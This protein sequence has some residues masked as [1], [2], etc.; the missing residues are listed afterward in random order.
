MRF[1]LPRG[2][3]KSNTCKMKYESDPPDRNTGCLRGEILKARRGFGGVARADMDAQLPGTVTIS[4]MRRGDGTLR[5][6]SSDQR[7]LIARW[8]RRFPRGADAMRR[9]GSL[10]GVH[11]PWHACRRVLPG[12]SLG[13]RDIDVRLER[14]HTSPP[15]PG[16]FSLMPVLQ[17]LTVPLCAPIGSPRPP[18]R[19]ALEES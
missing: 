3:G 9:V 1:C 11:R 17:P 12:R 13:L 5:T 14:P 6:G 16:V 2:W 8:R 4:E 19:E 7:T 15:P 18:G 10:C